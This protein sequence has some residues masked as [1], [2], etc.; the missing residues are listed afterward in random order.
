MSTIDFPAGIER[1]RVA[2]ML[3]KEAL[4]THTLEEQARQLEELNAE[5]ADTRESLRESH[6]EVA[7][8]KSLADRR[9]AELA[10]VQVQLTALQDSQHK[11]LR[12]VEHLDD[13]VRVHAC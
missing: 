5:L 9:T 1:Q 2:G 4:Q 7:E 12:S 8:A 13:Q 10:R 11:S 6:E 3:Y